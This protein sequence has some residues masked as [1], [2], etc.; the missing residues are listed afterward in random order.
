MHRPGQAGNVTRHDADD[1]DSATIAPTIS[2][3]PCAKLMMPDDA[4]HHR[5]AQRDDGVDAAEHQTVDDLLDE[6]IHLKLLS[7]CD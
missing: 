7:P 3:S 5:V 2:T 6:N 1:A 4:V